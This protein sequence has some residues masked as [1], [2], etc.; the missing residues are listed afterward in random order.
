MYKGL[1][2]RPTADMTREEWVKARRETL[3]GSDAAAIMGLSPYESPFHVYMDKV[4]LLPEKEDSEAMRQ[5]RDLEEYVARRFAEETG[6]K[7]RRCN[8]ILYNPLYPFAH[9][10][11][12]RLLAGEDAGLECKTTSVLNLKKFKDGTYP[13]NYYVQCVHYMAVTGAK[14]WYLAVLVLGKEFK[15]FQIER[16][17]EEIAALMKEEEAFGRRIREGIPPEPDGS[18]STSEALT[19]VFPE[20]DG[21]EVS[22]LSFENDLGAYAALNR[23]IKELE[24]GRDEIANKIK[25]FMGS[26]GRGESTSYRVSWLTTSRTGFDHNRFA[27]EHREMDL[28]PYYKQTQVRTFR[29]SGVQ[30]E[31]G[32]VGP[33]GN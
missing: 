15:I 13:D 29:V 5:G 33:S 20:S 30:S 14:R 10:N 8:A 23:K 11:V 25:G 21:G 17:E 3:G 18:K 27:A 22:L 28:S 32:S 1:T 19:A 12:D 7:V 26:A 6:K 4:G 9:A 31:R 16:N 2:F 24:K